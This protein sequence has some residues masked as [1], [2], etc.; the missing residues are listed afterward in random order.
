MTHQTTTKNESKFLVLPSRS[1]RDV[2]LRAIRAGKV[3]WNYAVTWRDV[4]GYGLNVA[5]ADWVKPGQSYIN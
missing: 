3:R 2:Y 4:A 5:V 1:V